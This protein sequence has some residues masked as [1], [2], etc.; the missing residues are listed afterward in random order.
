MIRIGKRKVRICIY[1]C[2][3]IKEVKVIIN[4]FYGSEN[5]LRKT[6]FLFV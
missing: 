3:L 4:M 6:K 2:R 5:T 1:Y